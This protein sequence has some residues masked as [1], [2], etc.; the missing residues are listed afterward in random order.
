MN[1]VKIIFTLDKDARIYKKIVN[2][3]LEGTIK[4]VGKLKYEEVLRYYKSSDIVLFP[5][6]VETFGLP[7]IEASYFKK[8]IIV[9][10]CSYSREVLNG[11]KRVDFIQYND[12]ISW[13]NAMIQNINLHCDDN[14]VSIPNNG[15]KNVFDLI[16]NLVQGH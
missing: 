6:Y 16:D 5:S 13:G 9:S 3:G 8:N 2:Y 12:A 15:W 14:E 11:Y 4:L 10:D 1:E 7:L